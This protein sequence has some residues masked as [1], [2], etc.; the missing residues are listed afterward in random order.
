[1][2]PP[3]FMH[4]LD[5][6]RGLLRRRAGRQVGAAVTALARRAVTRRAVVR[7]DDLAG[8]RRRGCAARPPP[9][10]VFGGVLPGV[11]GVLDTG[12]RAGRRDLVQLAVEREE[13]EVVAVRRSRERVAA[14]VERDVLGAVVLEDRRRVVGAR[15]GLEAPQRVPVRRVEGEQPAVAAPD[16][17]DVALRRRRPG[18]ARFGPLLLPHDLARRHVDG[19]ERAHVLAEAAGDRQRAAER[20]LRDVTLLRGACVGVAVLPVTPLCAQT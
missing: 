1:M 15:A 3:P 11:A 6:R 19:R 5:H 12:A 20:D 4:L 2:P 17:D 7:E 18:V 16:E 8:R 14:R 10:P 13:P 9:P